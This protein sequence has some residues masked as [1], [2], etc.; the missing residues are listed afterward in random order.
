MKRMTILATVF[1]LV[2][3]SCK[4]E[5]T[6]E[7]APVSLEGKWRM[8]AVTDNISGA[9]VNKPA[10]ETGDVDV[11]FIAGGTAGG[12]FTGNT[13][14][15]DIWPNDYF[16]SPNQ[17]VAI[18]NLSMTKVMETAWGLYFVDNIRGAISYSFETGGILTIKT[19]YKILKF[20]KLQ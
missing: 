3:F 1:S 10:S 19:Y 12:T 6:T 5:G 15:N 17:S 4:K 8:I 7:P 13:S 2:F 14:I 20:H 9:M 18:P 11:T 16:T